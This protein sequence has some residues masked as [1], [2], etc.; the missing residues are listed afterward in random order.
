MQALFQQRPFNRVMML[1]FMAMIIIIVS[2]RLA[3][4]H[5]SNQLLSIIDSFSSDSSSRA[6]A[7]TD[8]QIQTLQEKLRTHPQDWQA[9]HQLEIGRAHV[10][11]P[12]TVRNLVC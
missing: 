1:A 2:W 11:T 8:A 7:S 3:P 12:I 4:A 10:C 9:Y 6:N 5:K